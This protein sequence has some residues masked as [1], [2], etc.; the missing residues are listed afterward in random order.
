MVKIDELIVLQSFINTDRSDNLAKSISKN[1]SV[2]ELLNYNFD[3]DRKPSVINNHLIKPNVVLF[4]TK[5]HDV[6]SGKIDV[7]KVPRYEGD[8]SQRPPLMKDFFNPEL[9]E[10]FHVRKT[11]LCIRVEFII[12]KFTT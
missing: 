2:E 7:R 5:D 10:K 11:L 9:I 1:A 8:G 3:F 12:E 6:R 4:S